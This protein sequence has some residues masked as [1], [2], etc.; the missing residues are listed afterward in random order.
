MKSI[1]IRQIVVVSALA[2]ILCIVLL[3]GMLLILGNITRAHA[4]L[5]GIMLI[6]PSYIVPSHQLVDWKAMVSTWL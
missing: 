3:T 6:G 2:T 5:T 4:S 1:V